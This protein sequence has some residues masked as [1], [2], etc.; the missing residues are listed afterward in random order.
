M[1]IPTSLLA[2]ARWLFALVVP[3]LARLR[4]DRTSA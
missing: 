1:R 2:V 4:P 3:A